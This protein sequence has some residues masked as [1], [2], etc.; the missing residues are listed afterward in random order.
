MS[1]SAR[2]E[3]SPSNRRVRARPRRKGPRMALF[4]VG[5]SQP[6]DPDRVVRAARRQADRGQVAGAALAPASRARTGLEG[7]RSRVV[8]DLPDP[9]VQER[10]EAALGQVAADRAAVHLRRSASSA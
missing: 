9:V 7:P 5:R 4:N 1:S 10:V 8:H 3:R 6:A 2:R